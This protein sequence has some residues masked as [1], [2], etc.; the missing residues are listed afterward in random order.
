[1]TLAAGAK[2][3]ARGDSLSLIKDSEPSAEE[4]RLMVAA[5]KARGWESIRFSGGTP[6]WQRMAKL[7]ALRQGYPEGMISLECEDRKPPVVTMTM[8]EQLRRRLKIP[9]PEDQAAPEGPMVPAPGSAPEP[10]P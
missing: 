7:E 10:R 4:T 2:L 1:V 5:G 9:A 6:A 8:P 3:I